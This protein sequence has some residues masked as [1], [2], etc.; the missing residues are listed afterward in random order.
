M[1]M[2]MKF[3]MEIAERMN[4]TAKMRRTIQELERLSNR[5]LSDIGISRCDIHRIAKQVYFER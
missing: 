4:K 5:E 1:E 2:I 3:I